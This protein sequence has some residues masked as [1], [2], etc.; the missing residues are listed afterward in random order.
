[1]QPQDIEPGARARVLI[2]DDDVALTKVLT[3]VLSSE[4]FDVDVA[5]SGGQGLVLARERP[6]SLMIVDLHMS[7]MDGY[8]FVEA[9][10][11][12]PDCA[13]VP[14]FLASAD[15]DVRGM[16]QRLEGK[17]VVLVMPKPFDLETLTAAVHGAV[18]SD[19]GSTPTRA[20]ED[21]REESADGRR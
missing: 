11:A 7:D 13:Q 12:I 8:A 5:N 21:T 18:R 16:R 2:V 3:R 17:G 9:C 4:D 6:P 15:A 19:V 20:Q 10:R 14:V 1:M